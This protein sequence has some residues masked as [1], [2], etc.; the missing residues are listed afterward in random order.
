MLPATLRPHLNLNGGSIKESASIPIFIQLMKEVDPKDVFQR[1]IFLNVLS[2]TEAHS[3][4]LMQEFFQG[5]GAVILGNWLKDC[6]ERNDD[7]LTSSILMVLNVVTI[8]P[9]LIGATELPRDIKK[10]RKSKT[11]NIA[12]MANEIFNKWKQSIMSGKKVNV[13]VNI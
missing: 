3:P 6:I 1:V 4:A 13:C 10:L 2:R 8:A 7:H 11:E 5:G 12:R 9:T